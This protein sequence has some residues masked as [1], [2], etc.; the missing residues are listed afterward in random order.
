VFLRER[1]GFDLVLGNPPWKSLSPDLKEFF[2]PYAPEIRT[3]KKQDQEAIVEA[4]LEDKALTRLWD[5]HRHYLLVLAK[6]FFRRSGRYELFAPGNLGK[7]DQNI[8]RMFLETALD[9]VAHDGYAAQIVPSN[10]Y[11]GANATAIRRRLLDAW[12]MEWVLGFINEREHWFPGIHQDTKFALY[13]ARNRTPSSTLHVGFRLENEEQLRAAVALRR[14]VDLDTI[15]SEAPETYAIPE[16]A[17]SALDTVASKMLAAW[18]RFGEHVDGLP[19]RDYQR[20]IDM[21][22]DRDLFVDGLTDDGLPVFEGR[23]VDQYEY[24]AK[25]YISGRG[26]GARW[27]DLPL[28]SPD[29]RIVPQW[30]IPGDSVPVKLG[31]R[32][33]RY[34]VAW[35]DVASPEYARALK[36]A[37]VSPGTVCGHVVPTLEFEHGDT[38]H[39]MPLLAVLNSLAA[40]A[41]IRRLISLHVTFSIL[42]TLPIPRWAYETPIAIELG[43]RALRLSCTGPEML[44]YWNAMAVRGWV[45]PTTRPDIPGAAIDAAEREQLRMEI[46]ALVA[47]EVFGLTRSEFEILLDSFTQLAVTE[48]REHG[49]FRT[50]R[51]ALTEYDN[52]LADRMQRHELSDSTAVVGRR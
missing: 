5:R 10:F 17:D 25:A 16:S 50:K 28:G 38:W 15:R 14:T 2:E 11:N 46:E 1:R 36:A 31:E 12:D 29:K 3:A 39:Y 41:L 32:P 13:A 24:R 43:I 23:M 19:Y 48:E 37:L 35:N 52:L 21:G 26:R 20:E 33:Y 4:L 8:Y 7:G 49:E 34:R 45:Q 47:H 18:P 42:D 22:N 44:E 40:D 27:D 9:V 6:R 30:R 51:L